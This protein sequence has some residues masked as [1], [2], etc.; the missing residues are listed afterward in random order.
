MIWGYHLTRH[1]IWHESMDLAQIHKCLCGG[2]LY[3][4][5]QLAIDKDEATHHEAAMWKVQKQTVSN[6]LVP[7]PDTDLP[8]T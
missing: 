7:P 6:I 2:L 3:Q 5:I 8:S 4:E 1:A